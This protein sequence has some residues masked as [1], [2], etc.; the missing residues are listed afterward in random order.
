MS[1]ASSKS[2]SAHTCICYHPSFTSLHTATLAILS[3]DPQGS[4]LTVRYNKQSIA[5]FFTCTQTSEEK[6]KLHLTGWTWLSHV[7][8]W[9][10]RFKK[11]TEPGR[12]KTRQRPLWDEWQHRLCWVTRSIHCVLLCHACQVL[13]PFMLFSYYLLKIAKLLKFSLPPRVCFM[14]VNANDCL[15]GPSDFPWNYRIV[16]AVHRCLEL[17]LGPLQG[18]NMILNTEPSL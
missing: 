2:C 10:K 17:S 18:Q 15:P 14:H 7:P 11:K 4:F 5:I 13:R 16:W 6:M 9:R 1:F 8:N 12:S 3:D